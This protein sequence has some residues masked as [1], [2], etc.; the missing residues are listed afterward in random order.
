MIK[1]LLIANR[2][3]IACRVI[4]TAKRMNIATVA[5]YSDADKNALHVKSA[6][7]SAYIGAAPSSESY[8]NQDKILQVAKALGV[9]A[10]HPGYG[11]LSE[12]ADFAEKCEQQ[13]LIFIGPRSH[14]I[15]AMGSKSAAKRIMEKAKVPLVPGYH[16]EDQ[17]VAVLKNAAID[18]GFPVLLKAVAGGGGRGMRPVYREEDFDR[19]L[20]EAKREAM[21]SFGSDIM[22]VEKYLP[23]ARHVEVQVFCDSHGNAVFLGDRD[24]SIQRRHQKVVEEAPAPGLSQELRQAMGDAAVRAAQAI[25]YVGA[26]TVE[27]LLDAG[28]ENSTSV[29]LETSQFY[30][31]EMNTR[32]QVEHPVTEFICG[33]DLVQWQINVA[34]GEALPVQQ[35]EVR[36]NGHAIEVRLYAENPYQEFRP[37]TG[38]IHYLKFARE[39]ETTRVDTGFE[40]GDV[41]SPYYDAML[42]KVVTYAPA[43]DA[44]IEKLQHALRDCKIVGLNTNIDWL[45]TVLAEPDFQAAKVYTN[46]LSDRPSLMDESVYFDSM[47]SD[48]NVAACWF[49]SVAKG[50]FDREDRRSFSRETSFSN[51]A[52]NHLHHWRMNLPSMVE[53]EITIA[54]TQYAY[55]TEVDF[56]SS[57]DGTGHTVL[58]LRLQINGR[59]MSLKGYWNGETLNF[60][61]DQ[62]LFSLPVISFGEQHEPER[63]SLLTDSVAV[64]FAINPADHGE[65]EVEE[66]DSAYVAP[67][68]ARVIELLVQEGEEIAKGQALLVLEAMKMEYTI[69][70]KHDGVVEKIM[71]SP[72]DLVVSGAQLISFSSTD[73]QS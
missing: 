32:L 12:N 54:D 14:S 18:M 70:A 3:E 13:G 53:S 20:V 63:Y 2:G 7:E 60:E 68:N 44:A 24:C 26:G 16:G 9:D 51:T 15:K 72:G 37:S 34:N 36:L 43:R 35:E 39:S 40:S 29:D 42:A 46:F 22:L 59:D 47:Q 31:M 61:C 64:E 1:K 52:W 10:I 58:D 23:R 41:V 38:R 5:V 71:F 25:E 55:S 33:Q 67:M 17:S 57:A 8:L 28:D 73:G 21:N 6:D 27:F 69:S 65:A 49:F 11:F 66:G 19:V 56:S 30:F 62:K 45:K 4:R 48:L 50:V